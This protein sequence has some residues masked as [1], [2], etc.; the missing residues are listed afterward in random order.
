M[1]GLLGYGACYDAM[2][3]ADL[4]ILLG[5]DFPYS[6]FL[7]GSEE[8][9]RPKIVQIDA[10]AARLG[11]RVPLD[12]ALHGDVALTLQAVL[13]LLSSAKSARFLHRQLKAHHKA[14]SGVVSAYTKNVERMRPIHPEYVAAT[15]DDLADDDAVFTVDT[16]MC[17][18]WGARYITPNG[19]R[20][21]FGSWHHGTMA[22]ALPQAIGASLAFPDRQVISMSGDGGLGMLMGELLTVKL[23]Q[24][25]TKIVVF[26]NS[27][28]GMVKLEMLVEGLPD[29]GTDHADVDFA[30]IAQAVGIGAVR[31][32]DPKKLKKQLAGA[33][34]TPGPMLIDVVTDPDALS[35]P[36][37]ISAQQ[38]RGFATASTKIVL[39]GGVGKMLDMA[40]ANLRNM[41]R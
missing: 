36:P 7:P 40:A 13:P 22:N 32:T 27:S 25:N 6:E 28:L 5:T 14:L 26:N 33:L 30:A 9:R 1:S 35:M 29:H 11:R 20:R 17:N 41:P 4:V 39:G 3:E 34:A 2:H 19:R 18:V 23:H 31:I 21:L 15:L 16:G 10:E 38:I 24:L 8:K 12:L 37:K